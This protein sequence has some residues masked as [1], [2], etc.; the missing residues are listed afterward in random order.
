MV[1]YIKK[2]VT[3]K[4]DLETEFHEYG[5]RTSGYYDGDFYN[6]GDGRQLIPN[7]DGVEVY[8]DY[9]YVDDTN[10]GVDRKI[11]LYDG[12][13]AGN[14]LMPIYLNKN[15][16]FSDKPVLKPAT[17]TNGIYVCGDTDANGIV[18]VGVH[19]KSRVKE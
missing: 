8:V 6:S 18:V 9:V 1:D 10:S 19:M 5:G 12:T 15:S 13:T 3:R 14:V 17:S 11:T 2:Q 7:P 16:G 4:G